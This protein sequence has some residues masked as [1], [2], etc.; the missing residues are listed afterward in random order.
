MSGYQQ[1][2]EETKRYPE[3][4]V[5]AYIAEIKAH[6]GVEAEQS[7]TLLDWSEEIQGEKFKSGTRMHA[8]MGKA[9]RLI[10]IGQPMHAMAHLVTWPG[11]LHAHHCIPLGPLCM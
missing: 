9:V 2:K 3:K 7:W 1:P 10:D 6:P 11:V 8:M 5:K 4:V